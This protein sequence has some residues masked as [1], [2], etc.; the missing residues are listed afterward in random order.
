MRLSICLSR[1]NRTWSHGEYS[2]LAEDGAAC[3]NARLT[4][5]S[6]I[7]VSISSGEAIAIAGR[8]ESTARDVSFSDL[9]RTH[10][11]SE[12]WSSREKAFRIEITFNSFEG[13]CKNELGF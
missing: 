11:Y 5:S 9:V 12:D 8:L 13:E 1:H 3:R 2:V 7:D 6:A 4:R 10:G